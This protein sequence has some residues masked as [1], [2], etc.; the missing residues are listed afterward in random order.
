[1]TPAR[2]TTVRRVPDGHFRQWQVT[3]PCDCPDL[4]VTR[5]LADDD[6][7]HGT[8]NGYSNWRCRCEP[9]RRAASAYHGTRR[10]AS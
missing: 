8:Y 9:C 3:F 7:R 1:M 4:R 6:P 10:K 5:G 2:K